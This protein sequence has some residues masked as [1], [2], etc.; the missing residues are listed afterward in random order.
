MH[1]INQIRKFLSMSEQGV[2]GQDLGLGLSRLD[3]SFS[4]MTKLTVR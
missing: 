4:G 1:I 3:P 2:K